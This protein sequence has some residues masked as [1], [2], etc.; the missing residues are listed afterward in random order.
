M[1]KIKPSIYTLQE[2]SKKLGY[3]TRFISPVGA[4]RKLLITNGKKMYVA[5]STTF[6][7]YPETQRW[8]QGLFDSKI[9]TQKVLKEL[10][11]KTIPS[12]CVHLKEYKSLHNLLEVAKRKVK[13][14]PVIIKPDTGAR[15]LHIDIAE[16]FSQL[17][18]SIKK[19]HTAKKDFLVQQILKH[20]EYRILIINGEVRVMHKKEPHAVVGDGTTPLGT[21]LNGVKKQ[22]KDDVVIKW[23]MRE[24]GFSTNTIL[25][26]GVRFPYHLTRASSPDYYE[27]ERIPKSIVKW[28][29]K[30]SDSISTQTIGIDI[31]VPDA[32]CNTDA[33]IIIEL[34]ANPAFAYFEHKYG[35]KDTSTAIA[36]DLL[37]HYFSS[38]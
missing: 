16:N 7:F 32:L 6:G 23:H 34:N 33:Y 30:L 1:K 4:P 31:F 12:F 2:I 29:K 37:K 24:T 19:L 28:T 17:S 36:A 22:K 35:D 15:G 27:T 38:T 18:R 10:T 9:L 8:Q 13:T 14:Y 20:D 21:L 25:P 3:K 5:N 26:K 11:Y